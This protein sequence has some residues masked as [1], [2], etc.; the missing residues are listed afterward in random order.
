MAKQDRYEPKFLPCGVV[1]V[2]DHCVC[3][4]AVSKRV[5]CHACD[6]IVLDSPE[7][8]VELRAEMAAVELQPPG[9][10]THSL[11]VLQELAAHTDCR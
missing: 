3:L 7:W 1:I 9:A 11:R 4:D 2:T 10:D 8:L 5:H 6:S